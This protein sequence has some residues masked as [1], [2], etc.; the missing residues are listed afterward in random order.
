MESKT[1]LHPHNYVA[2]WDMYGLEGVI[3]FTTQEQHDIVA[4]LKGE[5]LSKHSNPIQHMLLRARFNSQRKYEIYAFIS[6]M[7]IDEIREWFKTEP[8]LMADTIRRIG[9]KL[10]SDRSEHDTSRQVIE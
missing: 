10:Y 1:H 6:Y 3:D 7:D 5:P 4:A 9:E 8:Q 2:M